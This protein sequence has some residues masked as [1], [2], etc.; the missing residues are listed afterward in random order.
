M[1]INYYRANVAFAII[2]P[3]FYWIVTCLLNICVDIWQQV[4]QSS[5]QRKLPPHL[6]G[7]SLTSK[8]AIKQLRFAMPPNCG[9]PG[10]KLQSHPHDSSLLVVFAAVFVHT[11]I[12]TAHIQCC[13]PLWNGRLMKPCLLCTI[14]EQA[15][16]A[17]GQTICNLFTLHWIQERPGVVNII[18]TMIRSYKRHQTGKIDRNAIFVCK[19]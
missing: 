1:L 15:F 12:W 8:P 11:P 13:E 17:F 9:K 4:T 16:R 3:T 7:F 2:F 10:V 5:K 19:L 6:Y 14:H 18:L